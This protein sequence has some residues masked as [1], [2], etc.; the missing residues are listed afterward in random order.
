MSLLGQPLTAVWLYDDS[1]GAYVNNTVEAQSDGGTAFALMGE[2]ADYLYFGFTR[3]HDA[4]I[5]MLNT[6]GSYGALTWEYAESAS[7]WIQFVPVHDGLFAADPQ[8]MLWDPI[9][10]TEDTAWAASTLTTSSP[11]SVGSVP[12]STSRYWIRVSAASVTTV[13]QADSITCRPFVTYATPATVQKQLQLSTAFTE[14]GTIDLFQVED[15]IRGAEDNLIYTMGESWRP[16]FVENEDQ[17]FNQYGIK[18]RRHPVDTVFDVSVWTGNSYD[19]KTLGRDQDAFVDGRT[20][21]LYL[22]TIFLDAVPPKFRRSY[23]ARRDQG[24]FKR[25]VRTNYMHGH[26]FRSHP[27][28]MQ[29]RRIAT[30]QACIDIVTDLDF[31]PLIPL[32]LDTIGLQQKVENWTQDVTNFLDK[33]AKIRVA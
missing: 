30:K 32:G 16:E 25:A 13:A 8:Y 18:L 28:R 21:M 3:R 2:A 23:S 26:N 24:A 12:D 6:A 14:S 33:F 31:S 11:H 10:S 27:L 15:L 5:Y 7:S 22:A 19:T 4:L 1:A 17:Q 20:G 9:G 29:L